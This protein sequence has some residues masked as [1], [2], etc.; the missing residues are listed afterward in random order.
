MR[1]AAKVDEN[2]RA[3]V[4]ALRQA[5]ASVEFLSAVGRG[6]PDLLVGHRLQTHL[7]EVKDGGKSASRR[8]LTADQRYWH[9]WWTGRPPVVVLTPEEALAAIGVKAV[10]G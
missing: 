9:L 5:G 10:A 1:R 2:Q 7:L 6:V 4:I 8:Q 3:I